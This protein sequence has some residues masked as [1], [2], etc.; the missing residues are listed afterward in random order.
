MLTVLLASRNLLRNYRRS[1]MTLLAIIV[2]V[3][4]IL[5]FGGFASDIR[6][7]LETS[8]VQRSGHLQIQRQGYFRFGAGDP[9]AYS[10]TDYRAIIERLKHD[11]VLGPMLNVITPTL[12]ISGIAGNFKAGVS[13]PVAARGGVVEEL[14]RMR[15]WN[16]YEFRR[17]HWPALALMGTG[18]DAATIGEG[19]ARVLQLCVPLKVADCELP[20][21]IPR[22]HGDA[23]PDDIAGLADKEAPGV[24]EKSDTMIQLLAA[25]TG[26]APNVAQLQVVKTERQ[27]TK[28]ADDG[29]LSMHLPA[30][31]RL[32]FGKDPPG[33][34]A[35]LV[36]LHHTADMP[37]AR[38]RLSELLKE[39][40]VAEPLEFLDF[41]TINPFYGQTVAMFD[42][43]LGFIAMMIVVIVTFTVGNTMNMAIM[44]RTV[45]IGTVRALGLRR[46]ATRR[47][48]LSEGL[49]LGAAGALS[50]VLIA[51]ALAFVINHSGMGWV[52]PGG[53]VLV[54]IAV[55][56]WGQTQLIAATL[57]GLMIVAGISAWWPARTAARMPIVDALRHA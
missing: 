17:A 32:L 26:G 50:G 45:E 25:T 21:P 38:A 54:P 35:I 47:L 15:R 55:R 9:A 2:G 37:V 14:N 6:L 39:P 1:L 44:E 46:A 18:A 56:V 24:E 33:V 7:G 34:T 19:V 16:D 30:A 51:L 5:M 41:Q 48:F 42:T 23:L 36:Q 3:Q 20:P 43:I 49:M 31:Q 53:T 27:A 40:E 12:L 10:I 28:E 57:I 13:K 22:E 52:P 4:A 29:M 11:P 8:Y